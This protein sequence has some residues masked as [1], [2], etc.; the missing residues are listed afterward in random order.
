MMNI[1]DAPPALRALLEQLPAATGGFVVSQHMNDPHP[2]EWFAG[3]NGGDVGPYASAE[4]AL[5][6]GIKWLYG[7]YADAAAARDAAEAELGRLQ[8]QRQAGAV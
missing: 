6:A 7:L 1:P 3:W 5:A 4:D 2:D 8:E